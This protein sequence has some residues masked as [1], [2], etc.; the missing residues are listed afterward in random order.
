MS[1]PA[2]VL[3]SDDIEPFTHPGE[4]GYHSQHVLGAEMTGGHDLL[5]NRG[6]VDP[7]TGLSGGNH[8]VNDEIYYAV[9]GTC[10]LH[11]GGDPVSGEGHRTHRLVEGSV[12]FIPA[13]TFH[14]LDNDTDASF[15]VLTI[16]PQPAPEG[17][18]GIHDL[19]LATWGSGF[20]LRAGCSLINDG[21]A[22]RVVEPATGW[23][24]LVG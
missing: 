18:N 7:H 6:T 23:D 1:K 10:L 11:L 22:A 9:S 12:V 14:R 5:L 17:A 13:G 19:R 20:R 16:W 15:V 4:P 21:G 3:R 2:L 24:S 8:P